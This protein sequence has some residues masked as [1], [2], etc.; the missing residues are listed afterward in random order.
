MDCSI[1]V[2][3]LPPAVRLA[4]TAAAEA[5]NMA[6]APYSEF[7]VGKNRTFSR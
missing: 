1:P 4:V 7:Y 6:Y 3:E 2:S 5:R